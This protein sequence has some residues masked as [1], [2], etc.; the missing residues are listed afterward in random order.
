MAKKQELRQMPKN[1][2]SERLLELKKELMNINAQRSAGKPPESPGRIGVL[3]RTMARIY[4]YLKQQKQ[5]D[6]KKQ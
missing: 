1:Q 4:T 5:E 3:K 6:V 2:L